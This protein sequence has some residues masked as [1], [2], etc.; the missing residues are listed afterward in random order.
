LLKEALSLILWLGLPKSG[1]LGRGQTSWRDCSATC[2]L[3][4]I[5]ATN[6]ASVDHGDEGDFTKEILSRWKSKASEGRAWSEAAR[7]ALA[8]APNSAGVERVF[9]LLKILFGSNQDNPFPTTFAGQLCFVTA[10]LSVLI[11]LANKA[12]LGGQCCKEAEKKTKNGRKIFEK[13]QK[14][15]EKGRKKNRKKAGMKNGT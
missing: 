2:L 6:G 15:A 8:M 7:I 14:M 11:K 1:R 10:T 4:Y 12:K 13:I 5:A 3:T 9:S